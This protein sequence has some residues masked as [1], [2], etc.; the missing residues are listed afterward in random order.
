MTSALLENRVAVDAAD[1][2]G[3]TALHL[4]A[5][6]GHKKEVSLLLAKGAAL[7]ATDD[8]LSTSDEL[9]RLLRLKKQR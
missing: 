6:A 9:E 2:G 1:N 7:E 8:E 4:A 5:A 3:V